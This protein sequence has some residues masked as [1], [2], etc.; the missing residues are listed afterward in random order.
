MYQEEELLKEAR[1]LG[2]VT[3]LGVNRFVITVPKED[4]ASIEHLKG[5]RVF[6]IAR[7]ASE[8]IADK[9]YQ[10]STNPEEDKFI[11]KVSKEVGENLTKSKP[12]S[13]SGK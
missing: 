10:E 1:F 2:R 8:P 13:R 11:A 4:N 3:T 5:K 7:D 6:V 9:S 12:K